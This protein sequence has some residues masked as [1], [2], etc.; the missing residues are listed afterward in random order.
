MTIRKLKDTTI[1]RLVY[2]DEEKTPTTRQRIKLVLNR[3]ASSRMTVSQLVELVCTRQ[4]ARLGMRASSHAAQYG[5]FERFYDV[6][7]IESMLDDAQPIGLIRAVREVT[8]NSELVLR[9]KRLFELKGKG[10]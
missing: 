4:G 5:L 1:I 6:D 2:E 7:G 10:L 8:A 9:P 3:L